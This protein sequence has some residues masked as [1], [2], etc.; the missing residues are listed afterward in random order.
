MFCLWCLLA[1]PA[2][3]ADILQGRCLSLDAEKQQMRV[4]VYNTQYTRSHPHGISTGRILQLSTKGAKMDS[5]VRGG[6]VV[7]VAYEIDG[8]R[9]R[10]IKIMRLPEDADK[11][12]KH[13]ANG[14]I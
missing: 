8:T 5:S 11:P 2:A 3:A 4:D 10:A 9:L 1:G 7:R 14:D 12:E 6:S 13:G